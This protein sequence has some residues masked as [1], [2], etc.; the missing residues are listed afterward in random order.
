MRLARKTW[1]VPAFRGDKKTAARGGR[2][3]WIG[4]AYFFIP[5]GTI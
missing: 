5:T 2:W 3:F 4:A 1:S